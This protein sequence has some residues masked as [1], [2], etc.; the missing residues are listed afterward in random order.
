MGTGLQIVLALV[1][2]SG[3]WELQIIAFICYTVAQEM[4][5]AAMFAWVGARFGFEHFGT[6]VGPL[7]LVAG[8]ACLTIAPI[9]EAAAST[10]N[11]FSVTFIIFAFFSLTSVV[12][13]VLLIETRADSCSEHS[14]DKPAVIELES[15]LDNIM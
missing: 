5:F 4:Y 6:L 15:V 12:L 1:A 7:L 10:S 2:W 8:I 11:G 13:L 3:L 9:V 14:V